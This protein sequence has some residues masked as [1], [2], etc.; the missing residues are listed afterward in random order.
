M[1]KTRTLVYVVVLAVLSYWTWH[2]YF[3]SRAA[4]IAAAETRMWQAYYRRETMTLGSELAGLLRGQFELSVDE[5]N[6]I[7]RSIGLAAVTFYSSSGNYE[8]AVLP[9]LVRAYQQ[10][11]DR[12]GRTFN[13]EAAARAELTWWVARRTP[14]QNNIENIGRCISHLYATLY[15]GPRPE[16]DE[17]G[18]LR[19]RAASLRDQG[20][21]DCDWREVERLL[22]KSYKILLAAVAQ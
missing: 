11:R 14:G 16:F 22:E 20:G 18:L 2:Q 15:D 1:N 13:P 4:Q 10:L 6:D 12:S 9:N 5:S 17:A 3:P 19:A 8:N 7:A 21:E